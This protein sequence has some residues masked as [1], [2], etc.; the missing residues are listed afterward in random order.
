MIVFYSRKK[1]NIDITF[2]ERPVSGNELTTW[3]D[4][5]METSKHVYNMIIDKAFVDKILNKRENEFYQKGLVLSYS[6]YQKIV[7]DVLKQ[8]S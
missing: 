3:Q 5:V 6:R 2:G 1:N 7:K 4:K 8:N